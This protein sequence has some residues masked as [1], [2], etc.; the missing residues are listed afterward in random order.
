MA[1]HNI[2]AQSAILSKWHE[3]VKAELNPEL[4]DANVIINKVLAA[5]KQSKL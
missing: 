3:L 5:Q 1:G 2:L 4:E